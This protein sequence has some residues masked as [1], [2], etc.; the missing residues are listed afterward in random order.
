MKKTS[1][2]GMIGSVVGSVFG[3]GLNTVV[4][5]VKRAPNTLPNTG[6]KHGYFPNFQLLKYYCVFC[7][8]YF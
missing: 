6:T 4:C 2:K 5:S 7:D 3:R 1:E 8:W